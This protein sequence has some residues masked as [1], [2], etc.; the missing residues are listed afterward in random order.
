MVQIDAM[1]A[2]GLHWPVRNIKSGES[3]N[4]IANSNEDSYLIS[5][6]HQLYKQCSETSQEKEQLEP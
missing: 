5:E 2:V 4:F 3:T 1:Y 6:V